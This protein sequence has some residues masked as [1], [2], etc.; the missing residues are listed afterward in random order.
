MKYISDEIRS[1]LNNDTEY[2]PYILVI[3]E[4]DAEGNAINVESS[5]NGSFVLLRGLLSFINTVEKDLKERI[6]SDADE[7]TKEKAVKIVEIVK[8]INQLN[9]EKAKELIDKYFPTG[10]TTVQS[11]EIDDFM[12]EAE[13]FIS[14]SEN[15]KKRG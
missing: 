7:T 15:K 8:K 12:I 10:I 13:K 3:M 4:C 5:I 9:P 14:E 6:V 1:I 11:K 2:N